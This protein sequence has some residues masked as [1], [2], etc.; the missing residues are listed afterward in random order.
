M[1]SYDYYAV[2]Y[3]GEVYCTHCL[4]FNVSINDD[5]VS[6]IFADSEWGYIPTC[7]VEDKS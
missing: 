7:D 2:I 1:K 4:P 3:E 6:P 5:G